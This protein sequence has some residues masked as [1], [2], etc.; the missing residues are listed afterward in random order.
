MIFKYL[1]KYFIDFFSIVYT[2]SI[3]LIPTLIFTVAL[4]L[5]TLGASCSFLF[6][7]FLRFEFRTLLLDLSSFLI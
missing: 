4:L 5:L 7:N 2:L 1:K 3:S 6:S